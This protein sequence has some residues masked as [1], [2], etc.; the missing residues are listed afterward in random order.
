MTWKLSNGE[1]VAIGDKVQV[2]E[3]DDTVYVGNI[4]DIG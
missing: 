1:S 2:T 4:T 3:S